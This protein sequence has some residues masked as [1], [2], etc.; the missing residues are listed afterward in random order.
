MLMRYRQSR[1]GA[2]DN[3]D[4]L[5]EYNNPVYAPT[6]SQNVPVEEVPLQTLNSYHE[7]NSPNYY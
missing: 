2:A 6:I 7:E 4:F 1:S 3:Q 5:S